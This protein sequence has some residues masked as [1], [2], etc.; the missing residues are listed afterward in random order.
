M[1]KMLPRWRWRETRRRIG[2][3]RRPDFA[4]AVERALADAVHGRQDSAV[5]VDTNI[6]RATH[7]I[8]AFPGAGGGSTPG[9][10]P[11]DLLDNPPD[12]L[13]SDT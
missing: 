9:N 11:E 7:P 6:H 2:G 10:P 13:T 3:K 4:V 1:A 5:A 8:V 12:T